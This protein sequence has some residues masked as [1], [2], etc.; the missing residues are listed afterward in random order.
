MRMPSRL[1]PLGALLLCSVAS[2]HPQG[3]HQ[4]VRVVVHA[5]RVE[6]LVVLDVDEGKRAQLLRAGADANADGRLEGEELERLRARLVGLATGRLKVELS[7]FTPALRLQ[8]NKINLRDRFTTGT[9]GL[10]VAVLLEAPLPKAPSEGMELR[11]H[12]SSPDRSHV[13]VE[14]EQVLEGGGGPSLS[15]DV[16]HGEYLSLRLAAPRSL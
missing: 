13:R 9:D 2:A 14:T 6:V 16:R 4:H 8:E 10:S 15:R 1:I 11:V 12:A 7:G 3:Y 5:E